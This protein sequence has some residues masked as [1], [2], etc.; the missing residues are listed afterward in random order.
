MT[1]EGGGLVALPSANDPKLFTEP[2]SLSFEDLSVVRAAA[3]RGLLVRLTDAGDGAG[4]W[5][6]QLE[7]QAATPGTAVDVAGTV[8]VPPGGEADLAVVARAAAGAVAGENYGFIVLTKD[9]VTRR[10]PYLFLVSDPK[11]AVATVLP[12]LETQT[13]DTRTGADRVEL[14][15]YPAAPFGN[16]PDQPPMNEN[17][18]ET[19][20]TT[21]LDRPAVNI[22]VS[23]LSAPGGRCD[24]SV[25]SRLARREHCARRRRHAGR[26]QR[27]HVRLPRAR[28]CRR[29]VVPPPGHVLHCG[30]LRTRSGSR[31]GAP[32]ARMSCAPG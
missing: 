28:R 7:P 4:M 2:T 3:D 30:R 24:R 1:L 13:G 9:A 8:A 15:R 20:Y 27:A 18:G 19:V 16:F 10:V 26:R 6:V 23:V 5:Q 32:A 17:G 14:Y 21:S 31:T 22:G 12:L 29:C 25:V 11:L